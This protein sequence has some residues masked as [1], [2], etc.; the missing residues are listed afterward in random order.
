MKSCLSQQALQ[1]K[2]KIYRRYDEAP[3]FYYHTKTIDVVN[4]SVSVWNQYIYLSI[5]LSWF[6][7]NIYVCNDL[8]QIHQ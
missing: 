1:A 3:L 5:K 4:D 8:N 2:S 6:N 7:N